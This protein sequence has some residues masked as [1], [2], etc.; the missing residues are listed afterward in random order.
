VGDLEGLLGRV[1]K[2]DL[3]TDVEFSPASLVDLKGPFLHG[4]FRLHEGRVQ[5]EDHFLDKVGNVV[6]IVQ[7]ADIAAPSLNNIIKKPYL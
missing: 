5:N 2:E 3:Y 7:A 1:H 6:F 4:L